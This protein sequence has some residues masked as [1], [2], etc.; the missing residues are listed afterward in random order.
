MDAYKRRSAPLME[1]A[2]SSIGAT[3]PRGVGSNIKGGIHHEKE[4]DVV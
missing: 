2:G 1:G 3:N 4:G